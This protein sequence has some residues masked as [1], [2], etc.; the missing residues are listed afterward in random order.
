MFPFDYVSDIHLST[1]IPDSNNTKEANRIINFAQSLLPEKPNE[2]LIIAGDISEYNNKTIL[3]LDALAFQYKTILVV[4]GNHDLWLFSKKQR[5]KYKKNS[6][7]RIRELQDYYKNNKVVHILYN[8]I[9]HYGNYKI[10]G[11]PLWYDVSPEDQ[12]DYREYSNDYHNILTVFDMHRSDITFYESLDAVDL[13][14]THI[15]PFPVDDDSPSYYFTEVESLKAPL[16]V[17]G[18]V[19]RQQ[20]FRYQN[21]TILMNA[22]GY[23]DEN[24]NQ[25]I[26]QHKIDYR[27]E[28]LN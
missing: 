27:T 16:W 18:H 2:L 1:H 8:E 13:M 4:P 14:V 12:N 21:A 7:S 19:H 20:Q 17:C 10:A 3:F 22:I 6:V 23:G 28:K 5:K 24:L 9:F 26:K 11:T 25:K 15:P